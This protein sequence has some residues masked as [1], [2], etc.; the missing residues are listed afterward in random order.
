MTS[1]LTLQEGR[2]ALVATEARSAIT[3][4]VLKGNL[5][6]LP[7]ELKAN[8]Y[9]AVCQSIGL[10]PATKPFDFIDMQGKEVLYP[11]KNCTDQLRSL[12]GI[13]LSGPKI[14]YDGSLIFVE[15]TAT[16]RK[17]RT[18]TDFGI[19]DTSA[20]LNKSLSRADAI[21]KAITKA[22]RRVTLS[23]CGLG[24]L[25]DAANQIDSGEA[26]LLD[27]G[28][29]V[30]PPKAIAHGQDYM[31]REDLKLLGE[32]AKAA[33]LKESAYKLYL[34]SEFPNRTQAEFEKDRM[35]KILCDFEDNTIVEFWNDKA[36]PPGI[37]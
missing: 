29:F 15:I 22:K 19:L 25:D 6:G 4:A 7:P 35:D 5:K 33:G 11:G 37:D 31:S 34:R 36:N 1:T 12:R 17:G 21:L 3:E 9:S 13:S 32:A 16:D 18:D 14:T 20:G 2:S 24:Y 23:I 26:V 30:E 10:N 27:P 28:E 8:Y